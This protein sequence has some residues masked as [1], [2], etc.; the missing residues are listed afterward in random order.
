MGKLVV[1]MFVTLD[2]VVQGPGGPDEDREG[3]F[4][5]GGWQAPLSNDDSSRAIGEYIERLDALLLGRKTYD[6]FAAYRR[7]LRDRQEAQQRAEV[8]SVDDP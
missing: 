6:N 4:E 2:G 7:G 3:G 5:H 8:R 1:N